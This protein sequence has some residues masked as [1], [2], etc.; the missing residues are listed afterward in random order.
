[1][2]EKRGSLI[3]VKGETLLGVARIKSPLCCGTGKGEG[4]RDRGSKYFP[5]NFCCWLSWSDRGTSTAKQPCP[6]SRLAIQRRARAEH[7]RG[8]RVAFPAAFPQRRRSSNEW[9]PGSSEPRTI[10]CAANGRGLWS[11]PASEQPGSPQGTGLKSEAASLLLDEATWEVRACLADNLVLRRKRN[12]R[13]SLHFRLLASRGCPTS[14]KVL[15]LLGNGSALWWTARCNHCWPGA[16]S[17][18]QML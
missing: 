5:Y 14:F 17:K 4:G 8:P 18:L 13:R 6:V 7:P 12:A 9:A 11:A 1:M 16:K 15:Y 3:R 2:P 10:S